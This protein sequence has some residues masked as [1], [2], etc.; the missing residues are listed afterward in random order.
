M[1][2]RV[3]LATIVLLGW[4]QQSLI[5]SER[6]N[7]LVILCD[8]LGYGD[9]GCYGS[10]SIRTPHLD[11][12]ASQGIRLTDCYSASPLCSPARAGLLTGRTPSRT[13]IYS[14]IAEGNPMNLKRDEKTIATLLK[15]ANYDTCHVGKWHLNGKFNHPDQTQ[16]DDHGFDHWFATQNNASPTHKNPKNFV[17]NGKEVG[18]Q[19]GYSCQLVA[20]EAIDWLEKRKQRDNPFFMFVCFHEPHEPIDSPDEMVAAYPDAEKR[21]EALYYANVT[22]MDSAVGRLMKKLDELKINEETLVIFTSDNGPETL[23]RYKS[24]WRSHGSSGPLRGMK[25]HVYEGGIRVPGIIRWTEKVQAGQTSAEPV[26]GVDF[27]PTL[28]ELAGVDV[29]K[30]KPLDG[31]SIANLLSGKQVER[32]KPLFWHY[33]GGTGNRQ[34]AL[35]EGDWKV[36]ARWDGPAN[37]PVGGSLKRGVVPLLKASKLDHFELYHISEDISEKKD[38]SQQFPDRLQSLSSKAQNLYQEVLAEGPIWFK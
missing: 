24:A 19:K 34:V 23:N 17:R 10:E 16:P 1:F 29:P 31:T 30:S 7:F 9:L 4:S 12:L 21:G 33:F 35:R 27:L 8:D 3:L 28:C 22:N 2:N 25:L 18:D 32:H 11:K 14:W 13:G 5:G 6:P 26:S 38:V 37:M 36:V 20:D 15:A